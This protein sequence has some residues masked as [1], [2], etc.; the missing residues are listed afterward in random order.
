MARGRR[1]I[2]VP[3]EK[4][5]EKKF[6]NYVKE[7]E[8]R[9]EELVIEKPKIEVEK[10][11]KKES[12]VEEVKI[13]E[14][15][16]KEEPIVVPIVEEIKEEAELALVYTADDWAEKIVEALRGKIAKI[17]EIDSREKEVRILVN[18]IPTFAV[19]R[20]DNFLYLVDAEGELNRSR[21]IGR[22]ALILERDFDY[23]DNV[24]AIVHK[25]VTEPKLDWNYSGEIF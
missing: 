24:N 4:K 16:K 2:K 12:V 6:E 20:S 8:V 1:S 10:V 7:V 3:E 25:G 19:A 9:K 21:N 22:V 15:V 14:E 18:G 23:L 11:E 13:V 5:E 17:L